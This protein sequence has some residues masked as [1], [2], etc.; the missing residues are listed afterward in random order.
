MFSHLQRRGRGQHGWR[1][2]KEAL[3]TGPGRSGRGLG[4]WESCPFADQTAGFGSG[5]CA[6]ES[7]RGQHP[8]TPLVASLAAPA[9]PSPRPQ[10][11]AGVPST[12]GRTSDCIQRDSTD[13]R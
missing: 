12:N 1:S 2:V 8:D 10:R 13:R 3:D 4:Q 9:K 6:E 11:T 5:T 7:V